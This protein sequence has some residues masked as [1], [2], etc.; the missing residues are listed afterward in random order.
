MSRSPARLIPH[1]VAALAALAA[2]ACHPSERES[3]PEQ[4]AHGRM[5]A[6]AGAVGAPDAPGAPGAPV[7]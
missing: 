1:S 3:G 4:L 6:A 5:A 2:A 7:T